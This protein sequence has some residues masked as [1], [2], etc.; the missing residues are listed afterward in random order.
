[1]EHKEFVQTVAERANLSKE[2]AADLVRVTL[3]TLG[4][5]LSEGEARRLAAQ[6]PGFLRESFP[7]KDRSHQ[8]GL[9]DFVMRVG[10]R[11]GLT[12]MEAT[13]GV[14]AVLTTLREAV[15]GDAF[16]NAM[17]QLPAEFQEM[18]EPAP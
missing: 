13:D 10:N 11:I 9:H 17:S 2:A 18:A 1:M 3:E 8:F 7:V 16:A 14:R 15:P 12:A 6:L 5:R 4:D